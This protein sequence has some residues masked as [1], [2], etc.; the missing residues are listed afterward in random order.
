MEIIMKASNN[1][2]PGGKLEWTETK[3]YTLETVV[4][5]H[6]QDIYTNMHS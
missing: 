2:I 5:I 1:Y 4:N 6:G 3:R